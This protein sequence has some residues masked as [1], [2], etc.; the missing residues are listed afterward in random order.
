M[1]RH[2]SHLTLR[3]VVQLAAIVAILGAAP[4]S[5]YGATGPFPNLHWRC[6]SKFTVVAA[7]PPRNDRFDFNPGIS[8]EEKLDWLE[9]R[10]IDHRILKV[11]YGP[12]DAVERRE[13]KITEKEIVPISDK[14]ANRL[15][16]WVGDINGMHERY[17]A[18]LREKTMLVIE[19]KFDGRVGVII[20]TF[21]CRDVN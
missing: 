11:I 2:R 12:D 19:E 1:H 16:A 15:L 8:T 9:L 14:N 6:Q 18:D 4:Q 5:T 7:T 10:S 20:T 17:A 3:G 21:Q 13:L